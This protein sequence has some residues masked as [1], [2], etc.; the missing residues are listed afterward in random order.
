[1]ASWP[2]AL[3]PFCSNTHLRSCPMTVL[4]ICAIDEMLCCA[5]AHLHR[6]AVIPLRNSAIGQAGSSPLRGRG[7]KVQPR[8][9]PGFPNSDR[10][11]MSGGFFRGEQSARTVPLSRSMWRGYAE[12]GQGARTESR[13]AGQF[14]SVDRRNN[15]TFF[16]PDV[17][18]SVPIFK[19]QKSSLPGLKEL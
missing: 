15:V 3:I 4:V 18:I 11:P 5:V 19:I 1:M 6:C 9:P 10:L 14:Y 7:H 16:A 8:G 13:L 2:L 12:R 17:R